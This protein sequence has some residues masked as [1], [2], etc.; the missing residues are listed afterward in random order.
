MRKWLIKPHNAFNFDRHPSAQM[1]HGRWK[2]LKTISNSKDKEY[3]LLFK[4]NSRLLNEIM[5]LKST[6]L[7]VVTVLL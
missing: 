5:R 3:N 7:T 1:M 4:E 6:L 2:M